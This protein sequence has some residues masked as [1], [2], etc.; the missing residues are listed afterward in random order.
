MRK[1]YEQRR[2]ARADRF[3]ASLTDESEFF[4]LIGAGCPDSFYRIYVRLT[5]ESRTWWR[6]EV[7]AGPS[8]IN[9]IKRQGNMNVADRA[10]AMWGPIP[11]LAD[12]TY[13]PEKLS[14]A[15]FNSRSLV[16]QPSLNPMLRRQKKNVQSTNIYSIQARASS[17]VE[18]A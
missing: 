1:S 17:T 3:V 10:V 5:K 13:D 12:Y 11:F 4:G 15:K 9:P 16:I 6:F 18:L 7:G 14:I 8:S 2:A